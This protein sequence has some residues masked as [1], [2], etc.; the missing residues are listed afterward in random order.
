MPRAGGSPARFPLGTHLN[1]GRFMRAYLAFVLAALLA[2]PLAAQDA[3]LDPTLRALLR[4][5]ERARDAPSSLRVATADA[6]ETF[7]FGLAIEAGAPGEEPRI[8]IFVR[9]ASPAGLDALRDAGAEI[10]SVIGD[11]VTARVPVSALA[12][13]GQSP[14]L[15]SIEAARVVPVE[16]DSS[17]AAIDVERLRT[18]AG[19]RFVGAT[20][21]GS[22]VA[23]YDTGLDLLHQDFID[24]NG[25][26]RVLGVW[27]QVNQTRRPPP[28]FNRGFYC[29]REAVQQRI[30]GTLS[31]CP[32]QDFQGHGT[33]VTGTAAGDGSAGSTPFQ[34]AGVAP[35]ADLLIVKGGPG[36]FFEDLIIDGLNWLKQESQRLGRS[37]V[38]NLSLG[39]Q[40]GPHDGTRLY[41]QAI[42]AL[43]GPG[44][45]VVVSAGNQGSNE[46]TTP[47]LSAPLIHARGFANGTET[48]EFELLL[49]A[50]SPTSCASTFVAMDFWYQGTDQLRIDVVR[51]GGATTSASTGQLVEDDDPQGNVEIDNATDGLDPENGDREAL[52]VIDA[53]GASG[54]RPAQGT[55]R[56]RVTPEQPGSGAPYDLWIYSQQLGGDGVASGGAGFD[57]Q[58]IVGS[59][60]NATR[61]IT[62]GAFVTRLCWPTE[63]AP[64]ICYVQR[65]DKGDLARFSGGGPRRDEVL[66]PDVAAPGLGVGSAKS[67]DVSAPAQ[68]ILPD[69][70]H[71]VIEGT[72][73][74]APHVTGAIAIMYGSRPAL[75]PEEFTAALQ[76]TAGQD[77]FTTRTYGTP[78][79]APDP[80][81]WWGYGKLNVRDAL[82]ELGGDEPS[83][84]ALSSQTAIPDTTTLGRQGTRLP[85]LRLQLGSL[86]GEPIQVLGLSFDVR[87]NDAGARLLLVE[88]ANANGR[89]DPSEPVLGS[90]PAL[91]N[92]DVT[93]IEISPQS[94][95]VPEF[96]QRALLVAL[97]LSGA[98]P[99][100][101]NFEATFI[102]DATRSIGLTSQVE[103][104]LSI[105]SQPVPSGVAETTVLGQG[106]RVSLSENP[107]RN[108]EVIFNFIETPATAAV[109][110]VGGRRVVDLGRRVGEGELNIVWDLT[111]DDGS[112]VAPGVYLL[113]FSVQGELFR[114]K[115]I[116][117]TPGGSDSVPD[118]REVP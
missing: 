61:A 51:P 56:I 8:G 100:G 20:G 60:G 24:A 71:W 41:E 90:A 26:T 17:M 11:I 59:P 29:T 18:L 69:G 25:Q 39:G 64:S 5:Q 91:L 97:E 38:V 57:N 108:P 36:S 94:L 87:G 74:A 65:E 54:G 113:V 81:H 6:F 103:N 98:A 32:Q 101:T 112:K 114:E 19:D 118:T 13:L 72:S 48:R 107:V 116:V 102:A 23:I 95:I 7:P 9:L 22:I 31:A 92:G 49:S 88:D 44:Y 83:R 67:R 70:V 42:D 104:S 12:R 28:G 86:G 2:A 55:W 63:D 27:D 16:H 117:L 110:T 50:Y 45:M 106:E 68:R 75:T 109:Y 58:Y 77:Q 35:N 93:R 73:M 15:A 52:I 34:F 76:T 99:N 79:P 46:N 80:M 3:R 10:G 30:A 1:G 82:I 89:P 66:K 43:S 62:V 37:V 21:Q 33:H 105:V 14:A 84:L 96:S 78:G 53:C 47:V 4:S 111:N 40:Y 85:L 115:L